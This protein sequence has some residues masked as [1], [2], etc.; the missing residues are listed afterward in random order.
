MVCVTVGRIFFV[1]ASKL[2]RN[3]LIL[4]IPIIAAVS[5]GCGAFSGAIAGAA[6]QGVL[7][8]ATLSPSPDIENWPFESSHRTLELGCGSENV[9][10]H[11]SPDNVL[12]SVLD[13]DLQLERDR[14]IPGEL[15]YFRMT[16]LAGK[17]GEFIVTEKGLDEF[18]VDWFL[19][20]DA[21]HVELAYVLGEKRMFC[22]IEK[23]HPA[24]Y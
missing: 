21:V 23:D 17:G 16:R 7:M 13:D 6:V 9:L 18:A 3:T 12:F 20:H 2:S 15:R 8:G 22:T 5:A 11:V 24:S 4:C 10:A 19:I 1:R 14:T